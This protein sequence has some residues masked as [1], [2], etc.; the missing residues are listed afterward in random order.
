MGDVIISVGEFRPP[1]VGLSHLEL[2]PPPFGCASV[3]SHPCGEYI[4]ARDHRATIYAPDLIIF[5][6]PTLNLI[7]PSITQLVIIVRHLTH[8]DWI[9]FLAPTFDLILP[10]AAPSYSPS[11]HVVDD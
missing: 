7:L 8:H 1:M 2:Q 5:L 4:S 9:M 3:L 6:A 11:F 10:S